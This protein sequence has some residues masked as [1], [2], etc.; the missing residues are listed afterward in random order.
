MGMKARDGLEIIKCKSAQ[1]W[2][3]WLEKHR[4]QEGGV[5]L[6]HAKKASGEK[7]VSYSEAVDEALCYGWIDSLKQ[8]FDD[9]YYKQKYTPRRAKSVWSKVNV[10]KIKKL[11]K[12]G[13]MQPSGLAAVELAKANGEW[14]RAYDSSSTI[15][16]PEDFQAALNK[17]PKA[18][19]FYKTL[20]KT[21]MYAFNW[22]LQT[23]KKP[24]IRKARIDKFVAM[25]ERGEKL[26]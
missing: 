23:A 14:A 18:N 25:L 5:W 9:K 26:Y 2:H 12:E 16:M 17:N 20:N 6:L 21:N 24:E 19:K 3:S 13:K 4:S 7:S 15:T 11:T 1:E 10:A 22:R 8:T